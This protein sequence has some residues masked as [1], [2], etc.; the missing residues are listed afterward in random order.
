MSGYNPRN[1]NASV[2][3]VAIDPGS[4]TGIAIVSI[5]AR[6]VRGL[7][8]PS[9]DA[10]GRA[11]RSKVAYQ[12][13]RDPK[14]LYEGN[15]A[16]VSTDW[17]D[18]RMLPIYANQPAHE[19]HGTRRDDRFRAVMMGEQFFGGALTSGDA[20][21]IVQ[22]RQIAGLLENYSKATIVIEDFTLRTAVRSRDV[23]SPDRI[24]FAITTNEILHGSSGRTPF[25]QMPSYAKTTAT[26]ERLKR[27][28]LYFAGMPHACDAA[29]HAL[30]FLRDARQHE[31]LRA[32]AWPH[33]FADFFDED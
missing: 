21:E 31:E 2:T 17:L 13:G 20:G 25:L 5:D 8:E 28:G 6:W 26:D 27:A 10:L 33:K 30:T 23:T 16:K 29:R 9:Y 22:I 7:G 3:V 11:I 1:A 32:H 24:R 18:E 15:T 4:T 19:D 14:A 12:I